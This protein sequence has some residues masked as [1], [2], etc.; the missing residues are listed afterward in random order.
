M[1]TKLNTVVSNYLR[2]RTAALG[3]REAYSAT[4]K[5]WEQWGQGAA[6]EQIG[7]KE[8]RAFLDWVHERAV[9]QGGSNPGRTAN[10]AREHLRAVMAWA[11]EQGS[12]RPFR[13]FRNLASTAPSPADTT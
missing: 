12:W 10:K 1:P 6:L 3:T 7:R 11:W 4:V 5:K 8:I 13:D 2:A 9:A